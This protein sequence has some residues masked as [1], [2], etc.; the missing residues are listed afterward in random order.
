MTPVCLLQLYL[1]LTLKESTT[2]TLRFTEDERSIANRLARE[3][4]KNRKDEQPYNPEAELSKKD[5]T[6][7]V[8]I[9]MIIFPL[10]YTI[11]INWD[12]VQAKLHGNAP[13]KG[14]KID[15][16]LQAEDEQRLREKGIKK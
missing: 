6:A 13:S 3:E 14:A 9:I 2:Y 10:R 4:Q 15:A 5:P 7:P 8:S 12:F 1:K 16:E 11:L